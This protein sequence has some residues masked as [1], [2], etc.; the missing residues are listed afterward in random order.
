MGKMN[1]RERIFTRALGQAVMELLVIMRQH[2]LDPVEG[3]I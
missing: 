3:M 1:E 2:E